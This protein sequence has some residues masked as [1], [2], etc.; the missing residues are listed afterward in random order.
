MNADGSHNVS[1]AAQVAA[2]LSSAWWLVTAGFALG[3]LSLV[4]GIALVRSGTRKR[5]SETTAESTEF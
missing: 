2:R 5:V 4:G 3:A 1:V